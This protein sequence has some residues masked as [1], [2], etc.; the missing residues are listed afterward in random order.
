[1]TI[2]EYYKISKEE[3]VIIEEVLKTPDITE[4]SA[5]LQL[6]DKIENCTLSD[7]RKL[8]N[9]FKDKYK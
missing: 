5:I 9:K 1:M 4:N 3:W 2:E 7:A 6:N 8:Y